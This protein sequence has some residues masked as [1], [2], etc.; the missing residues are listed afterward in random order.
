MSLFRRSGDSGNVSKFSK[1]LRNIRKF[2]T[3]LEM[4]EQPSF[5]NPGIFITISLDDIGIELT[6]HRQHV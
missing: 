1:F 5:G 4:E 3:I 6:L 2:M